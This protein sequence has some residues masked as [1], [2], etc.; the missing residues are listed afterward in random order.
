ML[1]ANVVILLGIGFDFVLV[2][3]QLVYYRS[4]ACTST[5]TDT[6][7]LRLLETAIRKGPANP[8]VKSILELARRQFRTQASAIHIYFL[9]LAWSLGVSPTADF[10]LSRNA[11]ANRSS[12]LRVFFSL[13]RSASGL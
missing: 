4:C 12:L 2:I 9:E 10:V 6:G 8:H 13:I 1:D 11:N 7:E 3:I 5:L